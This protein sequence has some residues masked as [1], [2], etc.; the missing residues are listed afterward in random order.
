VWALGCVLH[1]LCTLDHTFKSGNLLG[2]VQQICAGKVAPIPS[3]YSYD[4]QKIINLCFQTDPRDRPSV[5]EILNM[6]C[7]RQKMKDFIVAIAEGKPKLDR[8]VSGVE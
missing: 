5:R 1:E 7:V 6:D 8:P 3:S 4:L 2:L